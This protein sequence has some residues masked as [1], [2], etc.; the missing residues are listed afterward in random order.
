M[1]K[2]GLK[3]EMAPEKKVEEPVKNTFSAPKVTKQVAS[4]VAEV[5]PETASPEVKKPFSSA[6]LFGNTPAVGTSLFGGNGFANA[7]PVQKEVIK[8]EASTEK[9][10]AVGGL[11]GKNVTPAAAGSSLFGNATPAITTIGGLFGN[12]TT[13][14]APATGG[15]LFGN[16][17]TTPAALATTGSLFGNNQPATGGGLFGST[18]AKPS[19]AESGIKTGNMFG[20]TALPGS[21]F[22]SNSATPA[23]SGSLFGGGGFGGPAKTFEKPQG[24]LF[25][26]NGNSMF[27]GQSNIFASKPAAAGSDKKEDE[28]AAHESSDGGYV[29]DNDEPPTVTL[30]EDVSTQSPF[31]K[32]FEKTV[33]KFKLSLPA[34]LKKNLGQGKVSI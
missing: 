16:T 21:L 6:G 11:F 25:A 30:G 3:V 28:A 32:L 22:G 24:S 12:N 8:L 1:Q 13:P 9:E 15:G 4:K 26:A 23:T 29:D 5:K 31:T 19:A 10:S 33:D 20:G 18:A 2:P 17:T 34:D 7:S 14:A 27:G